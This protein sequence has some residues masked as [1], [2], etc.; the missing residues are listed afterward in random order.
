MNKTEQPGYFG[1]IFSSYNC[2]KHDKLNL[3][4][5]ITNCYNIVGVAE[6]SWKLKCGV[7]WIKARDRKILSRQFCFIFEASF[8]F[9]FLHSTKAT[10]YLHGTFWTYKKWDVFTKN[11][12]PQVGSSGFTGQGYHVVK[13]EV[14]WKCLPQG[15]SKSNEEHCTFCWDHK[16][17]GIL[18]TGWQA[19][20]KRWRDLKQYD[21]R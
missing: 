21:P 13:T 10:F 16:L 4:E 6:I 15:I 3:L 9:S 12:A 2:Y 1:V 5:T 20:T 19:K 18:Q 14:I 17:L 7:F 11:N 8:L